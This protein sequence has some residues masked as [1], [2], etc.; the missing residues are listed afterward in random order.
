MDLILS[1]SFNTDSRQH[2]AP[3]L[4]P[5]LPPFLPLF[6]P[7][8]T[9]QKQLKHA[10]PKCRNRRPCFISITWLIQLTPGGRISVPALYAAS[11][12]E[13]TNQSDSW[14]NKK[15]ASRLI[16]APSKFSSTAPGNVLL[17]EQEKV[18]ELPIIYQP[19]A[20]S[21]EFSDWLKSSNPTLRLTWQL[22]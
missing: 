1:A 19:L 14:I 18:S 7:Q 17:P 9:G 5:S 15:A 6:L 13:P 21:I 10:G 8:E 22:V 20:E 12:I 16:S 4:P 2:P 11:E 3:S